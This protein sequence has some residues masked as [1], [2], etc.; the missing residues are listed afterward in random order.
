MLFTAGAGVPDFSAN[1]PILFFNDGAR[2]GVAVK[3]RRT[4]V[5]TLRLER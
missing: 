5:G 1:Q 2:G 3:A 4:S